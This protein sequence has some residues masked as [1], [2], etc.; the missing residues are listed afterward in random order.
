MTVCTLDRKSGQ[1]KVTCSVL[2]LYRVTRD[3]RHRRLCFQDEIMDICV[4]V[5]LS[6]SWFL[7][8]R[9]RRENAKVEVF[10]AGGK[11]MGLKLL[12]PVQK[13]DF[14]M[15]YVGEVR[16]YGAPNNPKSAW[17]RSFNIT[18]ISSV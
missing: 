16:P 4:R 13:G 11:G 1:V 8:V 17:L 2:P 7:G 3:Y 18:T 5:F 14:I 6:M 9:Q 10:N 15:E 12:A